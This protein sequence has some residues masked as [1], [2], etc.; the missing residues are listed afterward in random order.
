MKTADF[1]HNYVWPFA[2]V[3]IRIFRWARLK[4]SNARPGDMPVISYDRLMNT[5]PGSYVAK[6]SQRPVSVQGGVPPCGVKETIV[7][8]RIC[9]PFSFIIFDSASLWISEADNLAINLN[10]SHTVPTMCCYWPHDTC[11]VYVLIIRMQTVPVSRQSSLIW[12]MHIHDNHPII[13][14]LG[15]IDLPSIADSL[16]SHKTAY[17]II[18]INGG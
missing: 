5:G 4:L 13:M 9:L 16:V 8:N 2:S 3:W 18:V 17:Q 12:K 14:G 15:P 10:N 1:K 11:L 6:N 7:V